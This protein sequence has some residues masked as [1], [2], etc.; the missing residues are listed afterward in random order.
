MPLQS[1]FPS[2]PLPAYLPAKPVAAAEIWQPGGF[3]FRVLGS[4]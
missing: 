2:L 4:V 3:P 1:C